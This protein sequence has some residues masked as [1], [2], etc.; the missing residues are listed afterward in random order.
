MLDTFRVHK[1]PWSFKVLVELLL[2][3]GE[4]MVIVFAQMRG[5]VITLICL[6]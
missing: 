3:N 2:V 5:L 4:L 6:N 1:H